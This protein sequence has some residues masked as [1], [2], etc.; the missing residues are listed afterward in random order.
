MWVKKA[1]VETLLEAGKRG[2]SQLNGT[3]DSLKTSLNQEVATLATVTSEL[4]QNIKD[5]VAGATRTLDEQDKKATEKVNDFNQTATT[6]VQQL[7]EM[8]T[9]VKRQLDGVASTA[10]E[11]ALAVSAL[12]AAFS[13]DSTG[14]LNSTQ[15]ALRAYLADLNK[16]AAGSLASFGDSVGGQLNALVAGL[17]K[18]QQDGDSALKGADQ[19]TKRMIA[20]AMLASGSTASER[21]KAVQN[22]LNAISASAGMSQGLIDTRSNQLAGQY[23]QL[24]AM[25]LSVMQDGAVVANNLGV[26]GQ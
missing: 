11:R 21:S 20:E 13:Q 4:D 24:R 8:G 9:T 14:Q 18:V 17:D 10:G 16:N 25:L 1:G 3:Y 15:A 12:V 26:T 2:R 7:G 19:A 22:A 6:Y 23:S 5:S